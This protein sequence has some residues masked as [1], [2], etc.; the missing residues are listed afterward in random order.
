MFTFTSSAKYLASRP[1]KKYLKTI[2]YGIKETYNLTKEEIAA[3]LLKKPGV[4]GNYEM[5][6][7]IKL[8][9]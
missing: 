9:E 1:S 2:G 7:I 4:Y 3:Y 8:F 6:E 5:A